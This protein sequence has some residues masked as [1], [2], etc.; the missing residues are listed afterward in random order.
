MFRLHNVSV[1]I[2]LAA[3][4]L[5]GMGETPLALQLARFALLLRSR[6]FHSNWKPEVAKEAA[7]HTRAFGARQQ[8]E[9]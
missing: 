1:G 6:R 4:L 9:K 7:H 3:Q 2:A 8:E 5:W